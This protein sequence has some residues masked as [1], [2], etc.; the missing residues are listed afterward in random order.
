MMKFCVPTL[1]SFALFSASAVV[2]KAE[3]ILE[4]ELELKRHAAA[5]LRGTKQALMDKAP[6]NGEDENKVRNICALTWQ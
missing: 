6:S 2:S 1:L 4:D 5:S 3:K